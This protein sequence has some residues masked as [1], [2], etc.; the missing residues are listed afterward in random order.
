MY[1][2]LSI[3]FWAFGEGESLDIRSCWYVKYVLKYLINGAN[4][5]FASGAEVWDSEEV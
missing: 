2:L 4:S 3:A 5:I 1:V